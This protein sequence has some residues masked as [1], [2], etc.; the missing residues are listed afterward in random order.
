MVGDEASPLRSFLEINY[1]LKE[2]KIHNWDD[3]EALWDYCFDV[4]LGLPADKSGHQILLT[5]AALNPLKNR[6]KMGEI[7]FEKYNYGGVLF[8]YQALLTLMA[9][10]TTTGIVLDSG[11]GVS[12]VIPVFEGMI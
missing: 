9:E 4:K 10:G 3:M 1:P 12:H 2:G 6:E 8:E 7:M 5:E 11:D